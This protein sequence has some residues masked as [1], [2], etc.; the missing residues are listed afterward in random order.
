[1]LLSDGPALE[2]VAASASIPGVFPAVQIGERRLIDGGIANNTPISHAVDLGAERVY[3]LPTQDP[4]RSLA[5]PP[6]SA[7]DVAMHAI[8]VLMDTRFA[9]DIARYS[10]EVEL[11]VL[12]A[13]N[14]AR[15]QPTSFEHASSLIAGARAAAGRFLASA[16]DTRLELAA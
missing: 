13:A 9:A 14:P 11:I 15:V 10:S 4:G 7:L 8:G 2:A 6:R 3:V 12:P 16:G 1:V 5:A